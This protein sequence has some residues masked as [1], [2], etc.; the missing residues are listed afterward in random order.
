MAVPHKHRHPE[1]DLH[2]PPCLRWDQGPLR[3]H[4]IPLQADA[5]RFQQTLPGKK[6]ITTVCCNTS[7]AHA[8]GFI[9][10][11]KSDLFPPQYLTPPSWKYLLSGPF[12][13]FEWV[14]FSQE[15][16]PVAFHPGCTLQ[17]SRILKNTDAWASLSPQRY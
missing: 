15:I 2:T 16:K 3:S 17:S 10:S 5:T 7:S 6:H 14:C 9:T 13:A 12:T 1:W 4:Y 8:G 11:T